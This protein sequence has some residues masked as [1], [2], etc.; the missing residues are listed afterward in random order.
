MP[1]KDDYDSF[2]A[3]MVRRFEDFTEWAKE[4]WPDQQSPLTDA[5]F[6]TMR[7][8]IAAM[9]GPRLGESYGGVP[10][11]ASDDSAQYVSVTPMPW[12]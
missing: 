5:D 4:N 12:P 3:E 7:K 6:A 1:T 9:V 11:Q 10:P 8:E 2:A